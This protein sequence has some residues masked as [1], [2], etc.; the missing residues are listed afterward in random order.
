MHS[1]NKKDPPGFIFLS[2]PF[3]PPPLNKIPYPRMSI[4]PR[5][6]VQQIYN[7]Q[8]KTENI[9]KTKKKPKRKYVI[10]ENIFFDKFECL[11]RMLGKIRN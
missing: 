5:Y 6:S 7:Y 3:F 9:V 11:Y 8:K 1:V 2:I 10:C 4:G